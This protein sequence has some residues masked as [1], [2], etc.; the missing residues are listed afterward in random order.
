[1]HLLCFRFHESKIVAVILSAQQQTRMF[2]QGPG[3]VS[4]GMWMRLWDVSLAWPSVP[5]VL[6]NPSM[7]HPP[8]WARSLSLA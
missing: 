2:R 8:P 7:V 1:M 5:G 6:A 4:S 3:P